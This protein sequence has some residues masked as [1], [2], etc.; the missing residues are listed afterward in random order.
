MERVG[1]ERNG[2]RAWRGGVVSVRKACLLLAIVSSLGS[3]GAGSASVEALPADRLNALPDWGSDIQ[4]L[5][6]QKNFF[7][8]T[9]GGQHQK[10]CRNCQAPPVH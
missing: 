4:P 10:T 3:A 9:T 1:L 8:L 7:V 6:L 2:N 5:T